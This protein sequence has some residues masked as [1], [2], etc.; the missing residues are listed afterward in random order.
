MSSIDI[1]NDDFPRW[2]NSVSAKWAPVVLQPIVGSS[3][4]LVIGV[5]VVAKGAFHL[6]SANAWQRLKCLYDESSDAVIFSAQCALE[7]LEDEMAL[8][9]E[10]SLS[11]LHPVFSNIKIGDVSNAEGINVREIGRTWMKALSSLYEHPDAAREIVD[12]PSSD[13]AVSDGGNRLPHLIFEDVVKLRP[14][15]GEY[16]RSDIRRR[17][18][19]RARRRGAGILIDFAGSRLV[20]NFGMLRTRQTTAS[21][22]FIKKQL[23]DLKIKRDE[24]VS[25]SLGR[26]IHEMIVQHQDQNDPQITEKQYD[27]VR[28]ALADLEEQA[29]RENIRL[30]PM[31]TVQ[32]ISRHIVEL[33]VA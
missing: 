30:R 22:N 17:S 10:I 15:F 32:Q 21:A 2:E 12:H 5:A 13:V 8:R 29:D 25:V 9:N 28:S 26:N 1:K 18:A 7:A 24:D 31:N 27:D 3:E 23:W 4:Q 16:F 33:E 19:R 14:G 11:D 20:A 6:E